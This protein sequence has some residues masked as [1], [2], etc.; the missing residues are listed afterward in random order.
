[1][2]H[3]FHDPI[4]VIHQIQLLFGIQFSSNHSPITLQSSAYKISLF[5]LDESLL[6]KKW[7]CSFCHGGNP[8]HPFLIG[9]FEQKQ[10]AIVVSPLWSTPNSRSLQVSTGP[11]KL[12]ELQ[13]FQRGAR[14]CHGCRP[15]FFGF[16]K[17]A[18]LVM[19]RTSSPL[20]G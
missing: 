16:A 8:S 14:R 2:I 3:P 1:M 4:F 18:N 17:R 7:R 9:I 15:D 11:P 12:T 6:L 19:R 10:P 13:R 20:D 5:I